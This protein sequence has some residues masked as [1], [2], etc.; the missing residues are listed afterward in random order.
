MTKE[1]AL[2]RPLEVQRE[3]FARRRLVAT[4]LAGTIVW[5]IIGIAA[6]FL[7]DFAS[8]MVLFVGTGSIVYLG[9]GLSKL[10]GENFMDRNRPKNTF[11]SLFLQT[12]LM[13]VLVY[14][15]A[16]PFFLAEPTS[17]PLSVGILTGLMWV[18]I[19][20]IIGHW[21]GMAHAMAR[22][23]LV[24]VAW[25]LFPSH[26]F[27]VIPFVIVAV[28]LFTLVVLENRWRRVNAKS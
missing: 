23:I 17:L 26:R 7:G 22:T 19:T 3:E 10:T 2:A 5:A 27:E 6:G 24:L 13:S 18:P 9:M 15:I 14:S 1:E 4:P 20:W 28:Y 21:I 16:I 12:V 11:D 8:A 25:Y